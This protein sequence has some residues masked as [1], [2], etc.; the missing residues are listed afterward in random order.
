[1]GAATREVEY[2]FANPVKPSY[3]LEKCLQSTNK[4]RARSGPEA[5]TKPFER[6]DE[7]SAE[8]RAKKSAG[9][10]ASCF[11]KREFDLEVF[12]VLY[13]FRR[14]ACKPRDI[15]WESHIVQLSRYKAEQEEVIVG[16]EVENIEYEFIRQSKEGH[17]QPWRK[18]RVE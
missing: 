11:G 8:K 18:G 7:E 2:D 4:F 16:G 14:A 6:C 13:R 3:Q 15:E 12:P 1:V 17:R 5:H 10:I 9:I